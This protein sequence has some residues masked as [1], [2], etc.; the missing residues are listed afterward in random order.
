MS[1]TYLILK[2]IMGFHNVKTQPIKIT[3]KSTSISKWNFPPRLWEGISHLLPQIIIFH[4]LLQEISFS[5][6]L[7]MGLSFSL[8][9]SFG[10]SSWHS[11][12]SALV[13]MLC[14]AKW[15]QGFYPTFF[16]LMVFQNLNNIFLLSIVCMNKNKI[17]NS[18]FS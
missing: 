4:P 2:M 17:N 1:L 14:K 15:S 8:H 6:A 11:F 9:S 16:R 13:F 12:S 3:L 10:P 18:G 5:Y 7:L